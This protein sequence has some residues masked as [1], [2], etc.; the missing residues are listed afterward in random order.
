M[1]RAL[2]LDRDGTIIEDRGYMRSPLDVALLPHAASVLAKL[3]AE[4][5]LLIIVSNQS[6][7]GSGLIS[8]DEM[9]QVQ[10][11]FLQVMREHHIPI[12]DSYFCL[13][14]KTESCLCRKPSAYFLYEAAR[15]H[16]I[17]LSASFMIGDRDTDIK[18]GKKAGCATIFLRNLMFSIEEDLPTYIAK[19][20]LEIDRILSGA[21]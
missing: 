4:G 21:R 11:R 18:C 17:D 8:P 19:D 20:W 13:H 10:G 15:V 5:W 6:G 7:V 14:A 12:A 3:A 2:F 9:Q 16:N 1:R